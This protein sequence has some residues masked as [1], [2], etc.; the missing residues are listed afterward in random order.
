M[1]ARDAA[2]DDVYLDTD[3]V[4]FIIAKNAVD[5]IQLTEKN[6]VS[7]DIH[8]SPFPSMCNVSF[9]PVGPQLDG[10]GIE[11]ARECFTKLYS[12]AV[13]DL[14]GS[15]VSLENIY[16]DS[17][18]LDEACQ[19]VEETFTDV[20]VVRDL[21]GFRFVGKADQADKA[22][23][24]FLACLQRRSTTSSGASVSRNTSSEN[25]GS[26]TVCSS[27]VSNDKLRKQEEDR[28]NNVGNATTSNTKATPMD[29]AKED[30]EVCPIC[31]V[32]PTEARRLEKC[33]HVF[34]R[35]CVERALQ[36]RPACPLCSEPY[37]QME[38]NQP[39]DGQM[40][41]R[42]IP[43][44]HLPGYERCGTTEIVYNIPSGTQGA[45][46]PH[47]GHPYHGTFRTAFLPDNPEGGHVLRLLQRAFKQRLVFTIGTSRTTGMDDVVTWNDIHHKT[48]IH[49]GPMLYGYPDP[50]YLKRVQEELRAKGIF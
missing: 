36:I 32:P 33:K 18:H 6:N 29:S 12:D 38:G 27:A 37:G 34:C 14:R 4:D 31:L 13:A 2:Q 1:A 20:I 23:K 49:G 44:M 21:R 48:S 50:D 40:S 39:R 11:D 41:V 22:K 19:N 47:P 5:L 42:T 28:G 24:H 9:R 26:K 30:V 45:E 8:S 3:V 25:R 10:N 16:P 17:A 43:T 35:A 7:L 46:H 15:V